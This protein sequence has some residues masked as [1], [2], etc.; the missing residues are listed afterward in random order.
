MGENLDEAMADA[1]WRC[2]VCR[3]ICNCSGANC[4][5]AKRNLFPTQQLTS[6]ALTYGWPSVAHYLIT[7]A[8]VSGRDA[9]PM[10]DLPAAYT[11]RQRRQRD[12]AAAGGGG[13]SGRGTIPGLFGARS[14]KEAQAIAL[15]AKVAASVRAAFGDLVADGDR[16]ADGDDEGGQSDEDAAGAA[17][18][19][20]N[21]RRRGG[22]SRARAYSRCPRRRA[23]TRWLRKF[24]WF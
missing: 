18:A 14:N 20:S 13:G 19:G 16:G 17:E 1:E 6:E 15:R 12:P 5:R 11:E 10:L 3:D 22:R 7:T 21:A 24:R 2:P 8:I 23:A 9:P 4:L